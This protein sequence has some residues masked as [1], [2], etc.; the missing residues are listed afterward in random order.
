MSETTN[1]NNEEKKIETINNKPLA[2]TVFFVTTI[3]TALLTTFVNKLFATSD[4]RSAE[5]MEQVEYLRGEIKV[6]QER[7]AQREEELRQ[8]VRTILFK[9]AQI[10]EQ[11]T[12]IESIKTEKE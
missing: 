10:N 7:D 9:D 3:C 6:L 8:Y 4:D 1:Q 12:V 2:F 11:R 5:C